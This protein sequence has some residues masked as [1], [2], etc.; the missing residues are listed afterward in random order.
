[1]CF[2]HAEK[3]CDL[4]RPSKQSTS[5]HWSREMEVNQE[6]VEGNLGLRSAAALC[7]ALLSRDGTNITSPWMWV[8]SSY[9]CTDMLVMLFKS[10]LKYEINTLFQVP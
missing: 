8:A 9:P 10:H 7:S 5:R 1:M 3:H 2:L 6:K 4:D